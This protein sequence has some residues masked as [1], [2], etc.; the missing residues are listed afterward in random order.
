MYAKV[1]DTLRPITPIAVEGDIPAT[2]MALKNLLTP[3]MRGFG[4]LSF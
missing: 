4:L 2:E 1:A 3:A